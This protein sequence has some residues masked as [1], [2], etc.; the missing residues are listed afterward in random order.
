M[1]D[2]IVQL[3]AA[4]VCASLFCI[5]T[6]KLL[7]AIQQSGYKNATFLR[8]LK[9]KDNLL[10]NRLCVL[11]LCLV[12]AGT[13]TALC[14]SFLGRT[15]ALV[16]SAVPYFIL[17]LLFYYADTRYALKVETQRT[18]R[19]RRLFATYF[20]FTFGVAFGVI[21]VLHWLAV[22]NGSTLYG[23]I[24]Y[25]PFAV[26]PLLL[27]WIFCLANAVASI[28]ENAR[29]A[30]FVKG[31]GQV[32]KESKTLKIGIVGSYGKTSV[33]NVLKTI[34]AEK[35]TVIATPESYNTP[36]G[37]AKTVTSSEYSDK[38]VF[39]AEMGARKAGDIV[40]LC[41]MVQ[42]DYAIF[43]GI[44]EQHIATFGSLENVWQEKSSIF[45]ATG[46]RLAVCGAGVRSY[47]E[48]LDASIREKC[49]LPSD[50]AVKNLVLGAT[51]TEFTLCLE[52]GEIEV[53]T[54]LLGKAAVENILL[55]ALL[56]EKMGMTVEEIG[57]GIEKIEPI[58]HR[59][60]LIE[61]GGV[62]II[63]DGYNCNP[64]GAEEGLEALGRFTGRKC[65]V[66]PGIVECGILEE[67]VNMELGRKIA[68]IA[69]DRVILV[70]ETLIGAVKQ[71]Y[72][73]A[74]G[75][76][77]RLVMVKTLSNAQEY[78]SEWLEPGDAVLFLN[79]LP[80]VY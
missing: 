31:A 1:N 65:V 39:I 33:K 72:T 68:E 22:K 27:P 53:C 51:K 17:L 19:V 16:I 21:V 57:R 35:Y 3:V 25:A 79:D 30:K 32:L 26:M 37:I 5:C 54:R 61:N 23:L 4:F 28:F 7:G 67:S 60:Q 20:V 63:D 47:I 34:L 8:W 15:A 50:G 78:L 13:I 64:R 10:Y 45:R 40:E 36:I 56:A 42:P 71:G 62:Y 70:G 18:G 44:C 12:L 46:L 66:T 9:R 24:A 75:N 48:R 14:F 76:V 11:A 55:S 80:D 29:N 2:V 41:E 43:T 59:L 69:P 73:S 49:V 74:Q 6:T 58:P 77:E 52:T 38:E